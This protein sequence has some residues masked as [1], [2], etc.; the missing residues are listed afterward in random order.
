MLHGEEGCAVFKAYSTWKVKNHA[1]LSMDNLV[2]SKLK[3]SKYDYVNYVN[4][5]FFLPTRRLSCAVWAALHQQVLQVALLWET[6]APV[7]GPTSCGSWMEYAGI[8]EQ[9]YRIIHFVFQLG[10]Y[11][12]MY[13]CLWKLLGM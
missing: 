9:S 2:N 3:S 4:Y 10:E 12:S 8:F 13:M 11:A 1:N 5:V 7:S 6:L